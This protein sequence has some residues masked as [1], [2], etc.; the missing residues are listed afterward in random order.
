MLARRLTCTSSRC[1]FY[2][3]ARLKKPLGKVRDSSSWTGTQ[4]PALGVQ[5]FHGATI[6]TITT[7][8]DRIGPRFDIEATDI[9]I[10]QEPKVFYKILQEKI[11][12][13]KKRIFLATLYIGKSEHELIAALRQALQENPSLE[14]SVLTDALRGTREDPNPSCA[15]LLGALAAEFPSQVEIRMYHTPNLTGFRKSMLPKRLNEGWGLQHM[16]IYGIDDEVI[17][18]GANLSDDYFTNRQD[19]YHVFSSKA[20]TEYYARVYDTM[21]SMSFYLEPQKKAG[22]FQLVWPDANACKSPLVDPVS[23]VQVS[24]NLFEPLSRPSNSDL[25]SP[26][27]GMASV[28]PVLIIPQ[29]VNTELP[30][31][32][33]ILDTSTRDVASIMFTA[34][35]FN[36]DPTVTDA[37]LQAAHSGSQTTVVTASP[38]ANGFFGSKGVSGM[39]PSAYTLL[40]RR[41]LQEAEKV[42]PGAVDLREWRLGTVGRPHGWTYH[43]KGVWLTYNGAG[44]SDQT[45][46]EEKSSEQPLVTIIGSSNYTVRSY[47]LDTEVGAVVV[48]TDLGLKARYQSEMNHLLEHS[49][50]VTEADLKG[51]DRRAGPAVRIAM[52]IVRTIGGSL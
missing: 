3:V 51:G 15:S 17:I 52:W 25:T 16:K 39:L 18:S 34:G 11:L 14:V 24:K 2:K 37:V 48:T 32:M 9:D 33:A 50:R 1:T 20:I 29:A 13:A 10:I 5:P 19:R 12:N 7:E 44:N 46:G 45:V 35:Y 49:R 40:A 22:S 30:A 47:S 4:Q 41:F 31:L 38:W 6:Q 28:Y 43:A 23:F 27:A 36:P 26:K 8:L 42:A 21:C